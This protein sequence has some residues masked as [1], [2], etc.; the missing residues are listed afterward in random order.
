MA[1]RTATKMEQV[2]NPVTGAIADATIGVHSEC[3]YSVLD[4][5]GD[6]GVTITGPVIFY[7]YLVQVALSA[8]TVAILDGAVTIQ[9]LAASTAV[10]T[11]VD[12]PGVRFETSLKVTPNASSTGILVLF[13]KLA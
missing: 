5:S 12:F 1:Q 13:Y 10:N 4:L 3:L 6:A 8:H 2:A 9:T 11:K 7:G